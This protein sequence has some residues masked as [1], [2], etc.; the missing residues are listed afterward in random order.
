VV[1]IAALQLGIYRVSPLRLG[2]IYLLRIVDMEDG[3]AIDQMFDVIDEIK[4]LDIE[5]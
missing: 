2:R 3:E 5:V 1:R 4:H